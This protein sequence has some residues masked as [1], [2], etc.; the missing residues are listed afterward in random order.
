[1]VSH[2]S[3]SLMVSLLARLL[4]V[5]HVMPSGDGV[6]CQSVL[7]WCPMS[8]LLLMVCHVRLSAD[9]VPRQAVC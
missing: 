6:P 7:Q 8:G 2:V 1:M 5:S 3:P 9:G 4:L